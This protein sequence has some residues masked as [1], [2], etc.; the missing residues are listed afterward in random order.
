MIKK[1]FIVVLF[2]IFLIFP[3]AWGQVSIINDQK[4][5]GEDGVFHIVGEIQNNSSIPLNQVVVTAT[6]FAEDGRILDIINT[7]S[8][9]ET[10]PAGKKGPFDLIY[11]SDKVSLINQYSLDVKY[12]PANY[13]TESLEIVSAQDRRDLVDNF[14]I[15]GRVVN[16]DYRTANTVVVI[17]TLYDQ[18]GKVVAAGRAFTEPQYLRGGEGA[19]FLVSVT[20][21]S[22]SRKAKDYSLIVESEEYTAV[23]EFPL[24][25][26]ITL[27]FSL[28]AYIMLSKK[29]TIVTA[30]LARIMNLKRF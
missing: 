29:P 27:L 30:T 8:I 22:Q 17:A 3:S 23:P 16:H 1:W 13:K 25:S 21:K 28:S 11:F 14:I 5:I 26:G 15:T 6:F 9:L 12:K 20:D 10:I 2:P 7:D 18:E 4:Y 24:G 19:P